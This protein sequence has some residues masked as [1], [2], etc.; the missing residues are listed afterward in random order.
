MEFLLSPVVGFAK[1]DVLCYPH[2]KNKGFQR[3]IYIYTKSTMFPSERVECPTP[4]VCGSSA[5]DQERTDPLEA[6][7]SFRLDDE[8]LRVPSLRSGSSNSVFV[9]GECDECDREREGFNNGHVGG[10]ERNCSPLRLEEGGAYSSPLRG[11]DGDSG[12]PVGA[13]SEQNGV[14]VNGVGRS[15]G[16]PAEGGAVVNGEEENVSGD[17]T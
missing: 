14:Y 7:G 16:C 10:A 2:H 5:K 15:P 6:C 3:Y 1:S 8:D 4:I 12:A 9:S 17:N 11:E 13:G